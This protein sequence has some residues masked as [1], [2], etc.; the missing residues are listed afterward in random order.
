MRFIVFSATLCLV[1]NEHGRS[2][3]HAEILKRATEYVTKYEAELGNLIASEE[4]LQNVAW[5]VRGARGPMVGRRQQRRTSSDFLMIQIG[6]EWTGLRKV[7]SLDG[8][9]VK[10]EE[11]FEEAFDDSPAGNSKRLKGLI[12]ESARHNIGDILRQINV[13]TFALSVMRKGYVEGFTFE[14]AGDDK[15]NGTQTLA[16]RFREVSLP[17]MVRGKNN[18][19]LFSTGT[20]WIE[21]ETGRILKTEF[22]VENRFENDPI[23]ARVIVTYTESTKLNMLVPSLMVEQYE[24]GGNQINCRAT[25]SNFRPF[26]V[27]VKFDIGKPPG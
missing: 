25:Y 1:L 26:T 15:I 17:T 11:T 7:N 12:E 10:D 13:P 24:S 5:L 20:L 16:F 8:F 9:K 22:L 2:A 6:P 21:P 4:Y 14:R 23:K 3:Q 27:D 18:E 19:N